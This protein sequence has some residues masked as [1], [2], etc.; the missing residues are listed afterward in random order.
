MDFLKDFQLDVMLF[1]CGM[2]GILAIMTLVTKTLP[3]KTK[4]ILASM[5]ISAMLLLL[6]DR[7]SYAFRGDESAPGRVMVKICNGAVYYLSLIIP[8]L[9]S[10]YLVDLYENE[11][12]SPGAPIP[13]IVCDVT[14][15][16]GIVL[17]TVSQ[18][19]GLYYTFDEHN[20][21]QRAPLN[22]LS[23]I[24]P[25]VM[26]LLQEFVLIRNR[27]LIKRRFTASLMISIAL[28][29]V[30]SVFQFFIYGLSIINLTTASVVIVFYTYALNYLAEVAERAKNHELEYYKT[31][32][33]KEAALFEQT[34][35]ALSNAIDAKDKYTRGHSSRVA[36]YSRQ[37]AQKAGLSEKECNKIYFA[38]LLHDVGKIGINNDIIN[39]IGK[40]TEEEYE[41][42]KE[43]PL[44]GDQILSSIKQAPFLSEGARHHHERFDG[45]GYPDGLEGEFIPKI[46]RIIAVA[47]AYDAMTSE[48]SY[49]KPLEK[50][51]VIKEFKEGS[52]TQ[53]D[54]E[55]AQIM[56]ELIEE[57]VKDKVDRD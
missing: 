29:S 16:I 25:F 53:F 51:K 28:P 47:D 38:A 23:Y 55:F 7:F 3:L 14:F 41:K 4:L 30:A 48:R 12:N 13:I 27:K 35:E 33:K 21:Y 50:E 22:F 42:I 20:L 45:K 6:F 37:I 32:Q 49:R 17:L 34:T 26:V 57:D 54:P 39:K 10:R 46:A 43:H 44:L 31:A 2:C 52:G 24:F 5:E 8:F 40:L 18:F 1:M 11:A 19:T 15:F 9:V 56:L 36:V